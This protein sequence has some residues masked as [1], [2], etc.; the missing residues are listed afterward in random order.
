MVDPYQF[1][2]PLECTKCKN[3]NQGWKGLGL[4]EKA[5]RVKPYYRGKSGLKILLIGQD[6]TIVKKPERVKEVLMLDDAN[7]QLSRW[8]KNIFG[9]K[10]DELDIYATNL[11]KCFFSL[12]PSQMPG[13]GYKFLQPFYDECKGY[14]VTEITKFCPAF[15]M[16]LG[17]TAHRL[18]IKSLDNPSSVPEFM[19]D[20]FTGNFV[21]VKLNSFEFDYTPCLHIKTFRVAETYKDSVTAFKK[22]LLGYLDS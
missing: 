17:Q 6:P 18:F 7:S 11:V 22:N 14:L 16:T 21:K 12:P 5:E 15:V 8:L 2:Y 19:K 20:A 1:G 9:E 3:L 4:S 13:G 10:F